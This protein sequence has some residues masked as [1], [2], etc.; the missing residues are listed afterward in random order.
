MANERLNFYYDPVRQGYD[1]TMLKTLSGTPSISGGA[2]RLNNAAFISYA[3]IFK[4]DL[5]L[6]INI[7]TAPEASV[8]YNTLAGGSF[9][10]GDIITD[11]NTAVVI[12]TVISD[13]GSVMILDVA[14][15]T[16]TPGDAIDNTASGG[17]VTAVIVSSVMDSRTW[18][19]QQLAGGFYAVFNI[20]GST[21]RCS[22]A[23]ANTQ[24]FVEIPWDPA[25]TGANVDWTIKW[26]GFSADF[27]VNG[28]RPDGAKRVIDGTT[29]ASASTTITGSSSAFLSQ[30]KVG[31]LIY[32]S[33]APTAYA[34]VTA[35]TSDTS[36]TVDGLLGNGSIQTM[37]VF[38]ESFINDASV[39]KSPLSFFVA[40]RVAD[41]M[42]IFVM[43]DQN[44]QGYI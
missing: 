34:T 27:L 1:T 24:T 2:I 6:R 23:Y 7:P 35:I 9:V 4:E 17:S 5:T 19:L 20:H 43:E 40:N 37:R 3:D 33:S 32:L 14:E 30:V 42:D 10:T 12:G 38:S 8:T 26:N 41:N 18:G 15:G 29:A 16:L 39:P 13:N 36:L 31:D 44:V 28:I 21:F 11:T 25:W 22:C